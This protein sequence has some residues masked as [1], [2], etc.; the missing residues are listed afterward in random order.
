[1]GQLAAGIAHEV[2]NP[3]STL[4]LHANLLLEECEDGSQTKDDV[5]T[6]VDQANRC[7][8]IISGLLNFA[9]QSRVNRQPTDVAKLVAKV[10]HTAAFD[11]DVT[12]RVDNQL[13]DPVADMDADQIIQ[14]IT[15]LI[16]NAQH[17][18]PGGGELTIT[19]RD[20]PDAVTLLVTDTGEGIPAEN[21][22]KVFD[23]FFTTKRVGMGTGLGLAV[24][25]GIV[26]MHRGQITAAGPTGTTFTVTLPRHVEEIAA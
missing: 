24:C 15:N 16:T 18:M 21:M 4:L 23:P 19:L 13:R 22:E 11:D 5:E 14:V 10:L 7:K 12:V 1:M 25:H 17:A 6:I 8:R 9:R 20:A 2:N 3:L 26:K